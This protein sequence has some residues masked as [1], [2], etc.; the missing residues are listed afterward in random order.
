MC[1]NLQK[2]EVQLLQKRDASCH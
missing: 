2:Y 1:G